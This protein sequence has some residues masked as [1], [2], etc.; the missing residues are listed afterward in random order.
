MRSVFEGPFDPFVESERFFGVTDRF[1]CLFGVN[2][3]FTSGV[4]DLFRSFLFGET[5]GRFTRRC[6]EFERFFDLL[7]ARIAVD[8]TSLRPGERDFFLSVLRLSTEDDR[9][10]RDRFDVIPFPIGD[11]ACRFR[12][13]LVD[14]FL[15][16]RDTD[17]SFNLSFRFLPPSL[18]FRRLLDVERCRC[19][20][21]GEL[22][23]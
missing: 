16:A 1:C 7:D 14:L 19:F 17:L 13:R 20:R 15:R 22:K 9:S 23:F 4:W 12:S 6:G 2:D 11:S 8:G 10:R 18:L 21:V 3:C 5:L